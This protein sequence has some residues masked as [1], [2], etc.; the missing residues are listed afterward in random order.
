MEN[1]MKTNHIRFGVFVSWNSVVQNRKDIDIHSFNHNSETYMV[2]S[3]F[4]E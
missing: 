2:K 4:F 1:D 3:P